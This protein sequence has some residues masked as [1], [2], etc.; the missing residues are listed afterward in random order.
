MVP[1]WNQQHVV[2]PRWLLL[3]WKSGGSV[4]PVSSRCRVALLLFLAKQQ[5]VE[6]PRVNSDLNHLAL[7][8][9]NINSSSALLH[10]THDMAS[11]DEQIQKHLDK[12][13]KMRQSSD[14]SFSDPLQDF[15]TPT[16]VRRIS[17]LIDDES[18]ELEGRLRKISR[19]SDEPI[20]NESDKVHQYLDQR[21]ELVEDLQVHLQKVRK[22]IR[23]ASTE[24]SS[25]LLKK[26]LK[27]AF[28][29]IVEVDRTLQKERSAIAADQTR[30][31]YRVLSQASNVKL[32]EAYM[33]AITENLPEPADSAYKK[34]HGRSKADQTSFRNRLIKAYDTKGDE[35]LETPPE[36]QTY[37]IWCPTSGAEFKASIMK[38]AHILP[39]SIGEANAAYLFG[40]DPS[41]GYEA[42]WSERN[43]LMMHTTLEKI[44]D[45]GR[46]V[47]VPDPMDKNEFI[48]IILSQDL[49]KDNRLCLAINAP[50]SA[51]HR[52]RLQF[53]T[54]ARP[55]KRYLYMHTL[56][57]LFRRRRYNV[58]GWE[59]DRE[60]M[61]GGQIWASPG[62]WARKSMV[63]A[64]AVEFG[65]SWEGIEGVEGLGEFPHAESSEEEKR[66]ATVVGYTLGTR[67]SDVEDDND[68]E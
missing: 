56:L 30:V 61:F 14:S 57:S 44:F 1:S 9:H 22:I 65:D 11:P 4:R 20:G 36:F 58:P 37:K 60:Q 54:T 42:I 40:C 17:K 41:E 38:A 52:R 24:S 28:T 2:L 47:I 50:Y 64:L 68:E 43:G 59:N 62:K 35:I 18:A 10:K 7:S 53:Q 48:S 45:D 32:G 34:Q 23:E 46:M 5:S 13:S 29:E 67:A 19:S 12:R 8:Y 15:Q 33:M 31:K 25:G 21:Q 39:Y 3:T 26:E 55:G 51:I 63:E 66:V 49:L 16:A 27:R 6:L